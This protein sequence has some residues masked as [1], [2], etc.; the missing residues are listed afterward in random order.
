MAL[1]KVPQEWDLRTTLLGNL[2][3]RRRTQRDEHHACD[4]PGALSV[5]AC[6]DATNAGA[7]IGAVLIFFLWFIGFVVLSLVWLITRPK[8]RTCPVCGEDVKKGRTA[9]KK[10]GHDFAAAAQQRPATVTS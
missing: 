10:C 6:Q 4:N 3:H 1:T 8:H 9:C 5:Q 2:D 7:G